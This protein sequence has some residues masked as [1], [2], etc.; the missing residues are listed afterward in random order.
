MDKLNVR[1][2]DTMA[3]LPDGYSPLF[4]SMGQGS[5]FLTRDWFTNFEQTVPA[6]DEPARVFGVECGGTPVAA[7]VARYGREGAGWMAPLRLEGLSNYY[8]PLFGP[9]AADGVA[10]A[11]WLAALAD[12]LCRPQRGWDA[13]YLQPLDR[14]AALF[15]EMPGLL[16]RRGMAVQTYFCFGNWYLDVGSLSYAEYFKSRSST[17]RKNVPYY[18]R[19]LERTPQSHVEI[20][21]DGDRVEQALR[22]YDKV[23]ASSW[24]QAEPYPE[25][26]PQLVRLAARKGWLR[27]GVAYVEGVPAAA[28][29]WFVRDGVASIF[30]VAYDAA[31]AKLSVGTVLTAKL[32]EHVIDVDRVAVVD[33]LSGDDGYK[34]DW[35][36]H[37]RER[38]GIVAFNPRRPRG[39]LLALRH[40]GGQALRRLWLRLRP[41]GDR[42][43]TAA[44]PAD[45]TTAQG[46]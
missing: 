41:P 25:F 7:L 23:Y 37:R 13:L 34:K 44:S 19:K 29:I 22:D 4:E 6:A 20:I 16:R 35:M 10:E 43:R 40:V 31:F 5:P 8:T 45:A 33:F 36:S 2:Y 32:M 12:G 38:W 24:K 21:A 11:D 42:T 1:T 46:S 18:A 9:A 26:I 30:K 28:Q 27:F 15:R 17:L 3:A 39:A 14:D